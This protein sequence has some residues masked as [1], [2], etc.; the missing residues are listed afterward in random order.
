MR[1]TLHDLSLLAFV[2]WLAGD[3]IG[4]VVSGKSAT[5]SFI[6]SIGVE[7]ALLLLDYNQFLASVTGFSQQSQDVRMNHFFCVYAFLC[8]SSVPIPMPAI[9]SCRAIRRHFVRLSDCLTSFTSLI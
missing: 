8:Y 1:D 2:L 5:F 7:N 3:I 6:V 4:Y 9:Y